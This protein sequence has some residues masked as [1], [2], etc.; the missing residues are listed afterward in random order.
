MGLGFV[1]GVDVNGAH[2][3]KRVAAIERVV[4]ET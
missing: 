3:D 2:V 1:N 4:Q